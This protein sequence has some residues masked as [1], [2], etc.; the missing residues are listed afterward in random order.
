MNEDKIDTIIGDDIVF[1][2]T[3]KFNHS[4]K[5]KGQFKGTIES[6][7][8]LFIGETGQVNADIVVGSLGVDGSLSGN[9]EAGQK[10][11]IGK[12][13]NVSGDLKTSE[14]AIES[15]A[16]FTGSCVM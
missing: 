2:G 12:T 5:I 1:K 4:L 11:R 10:I 8:E 13:A 15:G 16:K 3:L 14:L 9:V 7:G 6:T